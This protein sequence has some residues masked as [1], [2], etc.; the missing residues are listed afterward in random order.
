[1]FSKMKCF[2]KFLSSFL[3]FFFESKYC[4]F[5]VKALN[6]AFHRRVAVS[7]TNIDRISINAADRLW[8]S[9]YKNRNKKI[10]RNCCL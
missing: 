2:I 3:R 7:I 4:I 10:M 5:G 1:M 8:N 9:Q 6:L